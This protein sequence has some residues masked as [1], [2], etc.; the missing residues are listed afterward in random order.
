MIDTLDLQDIQ[1]LIIRGYGNLKAAC[2]ILLA[3]DDP[4]AAKS[5]LKTLSSSITTGQARPQEHALNLAL[6]Y[7]G[8][9]KLGLAPSALAM[10]SN[11][12]TAGMTTPHRSLL[13]GDAE[14]SVPSRWLWG[15]PATIPV[16]AVLLL[17][18]QDD[19]MLSTNHTVYAQAFATN[20]IR[21][22]LKLDT[23][24]L[25]GK[26]HFGFQDGISQPVIEGSSRKAMPI[27]MIKAGEFLLGYPNE[28]S[29]Y[30]DRPLLAPAL[31][32][33]GH[34]PRDSGGSG[35]VD[36]GRNGSY[37]VF[38]QLRQDVRGFWQFLYAATRKPDGSSD[39]AASIQ[40]AAQMVGRWPGGAPLVQAPVQ[41]DPQLAHANDFTY[42]RTD[43][44]GFNC[45]MGAH[46]RRANPRDTL[47]PQPGSEQS[48]A[49]GKRHR[50]LRRGREYGLPIDVDGEQEGV[51]EQDRGLHFLCF[52]A[53]IARQFEFIQH[54]W[55][56]NPHFNGLYEDADPLIGM[57][58]PDGGTFT[59][60]ARPV[61]KRFIDLPH[62]VSVVGGAYFFMPGINAINY[63]TSL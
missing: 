62:F 22:I 13:L 33:D 9:Q 7:T 57:R 47:D 26:E 49:V 40:L 42:Y 14:E 16:D 3:I 25:G 41:D 46:I 21:E 31:D 19:H 36:F 45:P 55:V 43:P 10:F 39:R 24:D 61:R 15:G 58:R 44:Y 60:Q 56:N 52:N 34:L 54:T 63:L 12:F 11:E 27:D 6:T 51:D 59:V 17:F 48:I 50:I 29:L 38:R 18:A 1:G 8:I 4:R 32:P 35:N 37:L 5:W 20:G 30:T 2:Y 28:Y 23:V 53:N